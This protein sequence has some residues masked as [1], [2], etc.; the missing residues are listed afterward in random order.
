[1]PARGPI[2][3]TFRALA[4]PTRRAILARLSLGEATASA[5]ARPF[6]ISRPAI[7]KHLNVL[8]NAG[9]VTRARNL[10]Q[11]PYRLAALPLCD[12]TAWLVHLR[13]DGV[14]DHLPRQPAGTTRADGGSQMEIGR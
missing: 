13:R 1:M 9:L 12:A 11:R 2:D 5:L 14:G 10:R 8:E 6:A 3:T 7:C 4:D